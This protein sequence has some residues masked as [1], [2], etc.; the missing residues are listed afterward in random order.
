[1]QEPKESRCS[2]CGML[3]G[4]TVCP[5]CLKQQ[6]RAMDET[7]ARATLKQLGEHLGRELQRLRQEMTRVGLKLS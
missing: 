5:D 4:L 7:Q 3:L 6:I 2:E 1:M